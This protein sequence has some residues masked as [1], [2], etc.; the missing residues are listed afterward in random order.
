VGQLAAGL[1]G[2]AKGFNTE[3]GGTDPCLRQAGFDRLETKVPASLRKITQGR[4]N[5][6]AHRIVRKAEN[7]EN[8][9]LAKVRRHR[10]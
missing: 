3:R 5:D 10:Q 2:K 1:A 9:I 7:A 6:D 8:A 4:Q